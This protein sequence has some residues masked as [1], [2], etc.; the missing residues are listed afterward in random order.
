MKGAYG[1]NPGG[2]K[3]RFRKGEWNAIKLTVTRQSSETANDGRIEVW[4]NEEKK[5]DVNGL[6]FVRF[7]S[8]NL[9]TRLAL[10]SFPGGGGAYPAYDNYLYVDDIQWFKG[11]ERVIQ[12]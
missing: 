1:S 12:N 9:I 8:A 10:E 4:C 5:I 6:R 7:E 2:H 3:Y 11:E